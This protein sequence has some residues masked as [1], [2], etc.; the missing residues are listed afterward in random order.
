MT[1]TTMASAQMFANMNLGKDQ[2]KRGNRYGDEEQRS[3][4]D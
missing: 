1:L 4:V 2:R 3:A